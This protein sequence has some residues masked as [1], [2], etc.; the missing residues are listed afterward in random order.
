MKTIVSKIIIVVLAFASWV[1][2]FLPQLENLRSVIYYMLAMLFTLLF[3][4]CYH[5]MSIIKID[6][7]RKSVRIIGE[8]MQLADPD[9]KKSLGQ[10]LEKIAEKL[11]K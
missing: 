4:F 2:P 9:I 3:L 7:Y 1:L 10:K 6:S 5:W 11:S 8:A